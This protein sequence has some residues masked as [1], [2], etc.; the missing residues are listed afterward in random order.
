M[1]DRFALYRV[2]GH[3]HQ[4]WSGVAVGT[5]RDLQNGGTLIPF[6]SG[7]NKVFFAQPE[8]VEIYRHAVGAKFDSTMRVSVQDS[9]YA[10]HD[11]KLLFGT[12]RTPRRLLRTNATARTLYRSLVRGAS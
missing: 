2:A 4:T 5:L 8:Y 6:A 11:V 3:G 1:T 10:G 9:I 12:P 7:F